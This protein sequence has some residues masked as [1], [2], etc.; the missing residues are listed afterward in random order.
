MTA[1]A[2]EAE[3][4]TRVYVTGDN[5]SGMETRISYVTALE[6]RLNNVGQ[7]YSSSTESE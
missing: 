5:E 2:R 6:T 3:G 1:F 4:E 7:W